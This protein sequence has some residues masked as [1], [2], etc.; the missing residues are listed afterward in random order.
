MSIPA[1]VETSQ[2]EKIDDRSL[3]IFDLYLH[4]SRYDDRCPIKRNS[5]MEAAY[6]CCHGRSLR[7]D[8]SIQNGLSGF[9]EFENENGQT[10][11][12]NL[13]LDSKPTPKLPN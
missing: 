4:R 7:K 13:S 6:G 11:D 5:R 10:L 3:K 12:G 9:K 1:D 2:N 8:M